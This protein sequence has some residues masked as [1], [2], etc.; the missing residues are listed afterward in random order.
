MMAFISFCSL[1]LTETWL[2]TAFRARLSELR[3]PD[4]T[5]PRLAAA[6]HGAVFSD[7]QGGDPDPGG[8][9]PSLSRTPGGREAIVHSDRLIK[10]M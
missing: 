8:S 10:M 3:E 7:S 5:K 6:S 1:F 4:R 2:L 9:P